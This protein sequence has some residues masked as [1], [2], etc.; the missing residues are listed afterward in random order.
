M[1]RISYFPGCTLKTTARSL[2]SSALTAMAGLGIRLEELPS[3]N[4]CGAVSSLAADDLIHHV[5]PARIL[6]R[7]LEQGNGKVVTLCSMCYNTLARTNLLMKND[8]NRRK[9][10][11]LF[12]DEKIDYHGQVEILHLLNVLDRFVGWDALGRRVINPLKGW[13]LAPYYGCTLHRPREISIEPPGSIRLMTQFL[14]ALGATV[15]SFPASE[16]CCGSY[17]VIGNPRAAYKASLKVLQSARSFGADALVLS[18]PLCEYNLNK[19]REGL[20]EE[21]HFPSL[22]PTFYFTQVLALALGQDAEL[23]RTQIGN[24]GVRSSCAE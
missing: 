16:L 14:S 18:C 3:W 4:C 23:S 2:E 12:M 20:G 10:I 1:E 22:L 7:V 9:R 21:E 15:I 8:E 19:S 17:T 13:R 6:I 11:M 5:A 24:Q